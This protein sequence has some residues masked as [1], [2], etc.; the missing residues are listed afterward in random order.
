[1]QNPNEEI[2]F[3]MV[4][5]DGVKKGLVGEIIKRMEQRGLKVVRLEMDRPSRE[6]MSDHYPKDEAWISRLGA[7]SAASFEKYGYDLM[8]EFGTT[9]Q[10]AIGQIIRGWIL[11]YLTSGPVVKMIIQGSH[12][13]DMVRKIIGPTLP[14]NAEM[15][16]VRGDFSIDS[17]ALAG[18]EKRAIHNLAHASETPEEVAHEIKHWFGDKVIFDY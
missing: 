13:I 16:T 6:Q 17:S 5:P 12:A 11:D 4:K 18:K 10:L 2:T 14:S 3:L 7:K 9:D 1:M 8:T 15:G